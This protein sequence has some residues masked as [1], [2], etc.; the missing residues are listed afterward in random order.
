[1]TLVV[2]S[3]PVDV[4]DRQ[5][6]GALGFQPLAQVEPVLEVVAHVVAAEGQH[7]ERVAAH[8]TLFAPAAAVVCEPMVAA[9]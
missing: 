2:G 9:R 5:D 8:H 4:E 6:L 1:M 3:E 7:G